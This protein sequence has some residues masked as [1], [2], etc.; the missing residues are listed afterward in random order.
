MLNINI[1]S[2]LMGE[3]LLLQNRSDSCCTWG[4]GSRC[5]YSAKRQRQTIK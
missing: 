5:M 3:W 1:C 4:P 2:P